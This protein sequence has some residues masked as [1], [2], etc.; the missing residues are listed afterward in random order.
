MNKT[1]IAII[2]AALLAP[3]VLLAQKT[4]YDYEKS[5][6]FAAFKTY[7]LKDGTPVDHTPDD[8]LDKIDPDNLR[9]NVAVM[10]T[11]AFLVADRPERL[12]STGLSATQPGEAGSTATGRCSFRLWI[13]DCGL[14]KLSF[15]TFNNQP[16]TIICS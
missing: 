13:V 14:L 15:S 2:A 3:A 16:A 4:T 9:R 1:L 7:A 8:T 11:M 6:N 10:A 5:A 12:G